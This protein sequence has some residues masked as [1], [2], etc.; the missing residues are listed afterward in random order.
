MQ[1]SLIAAVVGLLAA[2]AVVPSA[3]AASSA[4]T[5]MGAWDHVAPSAL[6]APTPA[7]PLVAPERFAAFTLDQ[8]ALAS[9]LTAAPAERR[10]TAAPAAGE[11][12][13]VSIPAPDGGFE[14]FA[15]ADSPVME[16]GLA[17]KHP[18]IKT[19]TGRGIDDPTASVRLDLSPLGFHAS[20]RSDGGQWFV[21]PRYRD[22]SEY[23]AYERAAATEDPYAGFE[24]IDP[25]RVGGVGAG[26]DLARDDRAGEANGGLVTLRVFRLALI[27]DPTY[28]AN[29]PD[30]TTAAK[31]VLMNR[32]N[33]IYEQDFAFH[34]DLVSGNDALNLD[35]AAQATGANGPCGA[36]ACFT[37]SQLTECTTAT[38]D[39]ANVVAGRVIGAG[40][41]DVAHLILGVNGGGIANLRAVGTSSKGRGCTGL[42]KPVGD[43]FAVDYVAHE[44][45]HQFGGD[46]SFNGTTTSSSNCGPANRASTQAPRVEPGSGSSVMA[47]AGICGTDDLQ[48]H[49]DPY[50]SQASITQITSFVTSA[51]TTQKPVQQAGLNGFGSGDSFAI[52]YNGATSTTISSLSATTI[53]NA[54]QGISTWP[55]GGIAT[56]SDVSSAGFT[57]TF[58]GTLAA[59]TP[60]ALDI[61][62]AS[63][64]EGG[65]FGVTAVAGSTHHGGT[66]Q[67]T[68]NHAPN[69][70]LTGAGSYVIPARTPFLLDATGSD[71]EGDP[72][73]YLWEENDPGG[74]TAIPLTT[75]AKTDGPLFRMFG[76]AARY[77]DPVNDPYKTPSPGENAATSQTWRSFPDERQVAAGNTNAATGS[78]PTAPSSPPVPD[79]VVD[80][81]SELLPTSAWVG[82]NND[83]TL[84][85]RVTARDSH[86]GFGGVG[87]ADVALTV[88]NGTGPFRVTSQASAASVNGGT[89]LPITWDVAGTGASPIN[90]TNVK[91]SLSLDGGLTFPRVLAASTANDGAETVTLPQVTTTT[92]R[93]KVQAIDNVFY[94]VSRADLAITATAAVAIQAPTSASLGNAVLGG[95]GAD[96][97]VTFTNGGT[98][99]ANLGAATII[100]ADAAAIVKASDSCSSLTLAAN[101]SCAITLRLVPTHS[102]AQTATLS[103]PSDDPAS[104]TTVA[105]TGNGQ[106]APLLDGPTSADLGSVVVGSAGTGA[107][108]AFTNHGTTA[109]TIGTATLGG[110]DAAAIG[111]VA[112]G[113]S[114]HT[115]ASGASCTI[116]VRLQ[117]THAGA[118]AATLSLPSD[119]PSSPLT[120]A[121]TGTGV[122]VPTT[123]PDDS[124]TGTR[125]PAATPT[126]T[127]PV[128]T[129]PA[130]TPT[131]PSA[132]TTTEVVAAL[133][134]VKT[135]YAAGAAGTLK[136]FTPSK[137]TK[138]GKPAASKVIAAA[139]CTGGTCTGKATAKLTL[140][141]KHGKA[142][143]S[144][145]IAVTKALTLRSGQA[146]TLTLKLT[147]KQRK[148]IKA[149]RKATLTLTVTNAT[150]KVTRTFSLTVG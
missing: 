33:Q 57:V 70:G 49:S 6:R 67:T 109:A 136:V 2:V 105:L 55:A 34:M 93:V 132:P 36:G 130:P 29:T 15:I 133:L 17:A 45:G 40:S 111:T 52:T 53:K 20:V 42:P 47:Y 3:Q 102:G 116:T 4:A 35:T 8:D 60:A 25:D 54:I 123:P 11:G 31:A 23:V 143:K 69:V 149:A 32:V 38:L 92:A 138:L 78:C 46:H 147:A 85:F 63:G 88:A 148:A 21:D 18:E 87:K 74:T 80:C 120:V 139:V 75:N 112:D 90:T 7:Q 58:D 26:S 12:L 142:T 99:T 41:Y 86:P 30:T 118:Q 91:I 76:T 27:S 59:G 94:D 77:A 103:L 115:L 50:F 89:S 1:K 72:V 19:Y 62:N 61:T 79:S 84:H 64:F 114:S 68:A 73:S 137:T 106:T 124:D 141:P 108:L 145:T 43:V 22:R 100:G 97:V 113:C 135:P 150:K 5:S 110:A 28:G 56:V 37:S 129:T 39:R 9:V 117:P 131:T 128:V 51:E 104:P 10:R 13:T 24:E 126:P 107:A 14:R 127:P 71:A 65:V 44:L 140:T 48:K 134:G 122:A 121:L 101:A 119:A 125:P 96:T 66:A 82:V 16:P 144:T 95:Q 98:S 81:Y 146:S 83:R